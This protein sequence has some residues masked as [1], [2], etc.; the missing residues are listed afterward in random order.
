MLAPQHSCVT[1]VHKEGSVNRMRETWGLEAE[2][3]RGCRTAHR[4][5]LGCS[6][7]SALYLMMT[8]LPLDSS[9]SISSSS[10]MG[11]RKA[12]VGSMAVNLLYCCSHSL[13]EKSSSQHTRR[14]AICSQQ[15]QSSTSRSLHHPLAILKLPVKEGVNTSSHCRQTTHRIQAFTCSRSILLYWDKNIA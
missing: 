5:P 15:C 14:H 12:L 6:S 8:A 10:S 2:A 3:E 7:D 13:R 4:L 9:T 11:A 1:Q